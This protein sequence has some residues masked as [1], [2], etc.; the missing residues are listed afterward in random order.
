M[1][2]LELFSVLKWTQIQW[3]G[4]G[5]NSYG[6]MVFYLNIPEMKSRYFDTAVTIRMIRGPGISKHEN[7]VTLSIKV[8]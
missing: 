3:N 4:G 1:Y 6:Q 7:N 8:K 2:S 5:L